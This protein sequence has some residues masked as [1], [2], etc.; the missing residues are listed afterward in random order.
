MDVNK[1]PFDKQTGVEKMMKRCRKFQLESGKMAAFR[2][3]MGRV[4]G[5]VDY[6]RLGWYRYTLTTARIAC[7]SM[8][9]LYLL[10]QR[11]NSEIV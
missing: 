5:F 6:A 1:A 4:L 7:N 10:L 9:A 2:K 8:G 3:A 11:G